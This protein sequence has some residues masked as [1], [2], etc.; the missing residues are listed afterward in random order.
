MTRE[1]NI[2][3]LLERSAEDTR[4]IGLDEAD[5]TARRTSTWGTSDHR[6]TRDGIEKAYDEARRSFERLSDTELDALV[7]QRASPA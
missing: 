6:K 3:A 1:S 7:A 5:S 4:R 2:A